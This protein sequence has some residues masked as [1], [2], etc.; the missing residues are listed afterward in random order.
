MGG[1]PCLLRRGVPCR[2]VS[3]RDTGRPKGF[4]FCEFFDVATA[5]SAHRNLNG[6]EIGGRSIRIDYAEDWQTKR[7]GGG[8]GERCAALRARWSGDPCALPCCRWRQLLLGLAA[9]PG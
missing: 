9:C 7:E 4:G 6:H 5:E 1:D 8:R 3:D 2:L